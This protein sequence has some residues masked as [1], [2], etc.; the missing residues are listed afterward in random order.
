MQSEPFWKG[1]YSVTNIVIFFYLKMY[2]HYMHMLQYQI[3][4]TDYIQ[5]Y[6]KTTF[7]HF[8]YLSIEIV[9]F[10]S[11]HTVDNTCSKNSGERIKKY[12]FSVL[13]VG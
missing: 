9:T 1:L 10:L 11:F 3:D 7:L 13:S 4:R 5:I 6:I 8:L 2:Y 12:A